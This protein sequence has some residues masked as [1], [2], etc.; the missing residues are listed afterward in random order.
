MS[1]ISTPPSRKLPE[2]TSSDTSVA[3]VFSTVSSTIK[4]P[5]LTVNVPPSGTS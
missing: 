4:V 2:L 5:A 1:P 3:L